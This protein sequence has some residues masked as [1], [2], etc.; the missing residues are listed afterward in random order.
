MPFFV[1]WE[2]NR[3]LPVS[4]IMVVVVVVVVGVRWIGCCTSFRMVYRRLVAVGLCS[5]HSDR[6]PKWISHTNSWAR[7]L[8]LARSKL[9]LCSANHRPGYWS[10]LPC[11]RSSTAWA[12]SEQET[13]YGPWSSATLPHVGTQAWDWNHLHWSHLI[14]A[15]ESRVS[16]WS[17]RGCAQICRRVVERIV[18]GCI[19]E[20]KRSVAE[21]DFVSLSKYHMRPVL[22]VP[23]LV[24][25]Y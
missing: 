20:I 4:R 25:V 19:Q 9:R 15:I 23:G 1:S 8:S 13:E 14:L 2:G 24:T 22:I 17:D 7:F 5:R 21:A 16:P 6:C 3:F 10:N 12:Y 18:H 11:D